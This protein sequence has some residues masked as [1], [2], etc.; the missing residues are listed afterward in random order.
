MQV[1]VIKT[2]IAS[3]ASATEKQCPTPCSARIASQRRVTE[4][5]LHARLLLGG[6][7]GSLASA[8]PTRIDATAFAQIVLLLGWSA[9]VLLRKKEDVSPTLV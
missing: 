3:E 6:Q 5:S 7:F 2:A 1:F 9:K 4:G 8:S